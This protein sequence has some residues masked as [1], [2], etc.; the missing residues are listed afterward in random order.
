MKRQIV[1]VGLGRLGLSAAREL[2]ARGQEVLGIDRSEQVVQ[3]AATTLTHA[4]V[5]DGMDETALSQ[6]G[7]GHF[8]LAIV[9]LG[10]E[11]LASILTTMALSEPRGW[12]GLRTEDAYWFDIVL[13][14][15]F[16]DDPTAD[17]Y[18]NADYSPCDGCGTLYVR[19][20]EQTD[21]TVCPDLSFLWNGGLTHPAPTDFALSIRD[22]L[23]G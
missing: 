17:P 2:V 6:L 8:D 7:V 5:A 10:K 21:I 19:G 14:P 18:D 13:Q 20:L 9:A 15:R 1:V 23:G 3:T 4:V 11:A 16:D 12:I 22:Q